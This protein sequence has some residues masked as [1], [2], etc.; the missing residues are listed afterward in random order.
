[1][2]LEDLPSNSRRPAD[3][4]KSPPSSEEPKLVKVE[5]IGKVVRR[6]KPFGR[7]LMDNFFRGDTGVL[8][9]LF[10]EVLIPAAQTLVTDMV[11][12]GIEK[13]VYGEVRTP[14]RR[15][16]RGV[17]QYPVRGPH[18]SYDRMQQN[19]IVR[20]P[21]MGIGPGPTRRPVV[22]QQTA[23]IDLGDIVL[24][25]E[26]AAQ[27][28]VEKLYEAMEEYGAATVA[29]LKELLGETSVYTDHNWGWPD[30]AE[31]HI[32][33]IRDGFLLSYPDPVDL[34]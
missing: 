7:R 6:K 1:M 24:E 5:G 13:A 34:R 14:A 23:S 12:Q 11:T 16:V 9:Y 32:K 3:P 17:S 18:V 21:Q 28:I 8:S 20:G 27:T 2:S 26:F 19:T 25:T 31:F 29:N 30:G 10:R 15:P 4:H 33:R 22:Q